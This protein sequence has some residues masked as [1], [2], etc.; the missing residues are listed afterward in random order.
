MHRKEGDHVEPRRQLA[1]S[2]EDAH[3]R[4]EGMT[5]VVTRILHDD[6]QPHHPL[7]DLRRIEVGERARV[8]GVVPVCSI[9]EEIEEGAVR[10]TSE[11][12]SRERVNELAKDEDARGGGGVNSELGCCSAPGGL[13]HE[14]EGLDTS[15]EGEGRGEIYC[16]HRGSGQGSVPDASTPH[17]LA[18]LP[19]DSRIPR[20]RRA[21]GLA[22]ERRIKSHSKIPRTIRLVV[23]PKAMHKCI[24]RQKTRS[25]Q[26]AND[27]ARPVT[28][29][30]LCRSNHRPLQQHF[31]VAIKRYVEGRTG[32]KGWLEVVNRKHA[33]NGRLLLLDVLALLVD[34]GLRGF[35]SDGR[36]KKN[37]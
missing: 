24:Y 29:K 9:C 37:E 31:S 34:A 25:P 21:R 27:T 19:A 13:R 20:V 11:L 32:D 14:H 8:G 33:V 30:S 18:T 4:E 6:C 3:P 35:F 7:C 28:V 22:L 10:G 23:V 12:G 1:Q 5:H 16:A 15:A 2:T 17:I 36:I 26:H